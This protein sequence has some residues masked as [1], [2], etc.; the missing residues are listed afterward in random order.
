MKIAL[1]GQKKLSKIQ[2]SH[3]TKKIKETADFLY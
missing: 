1:L 2:V 3:K